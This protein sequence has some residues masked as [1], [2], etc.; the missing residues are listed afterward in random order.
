MDEARRPR[1]GDKA[2]AEEVTRAYDAARAERRL[3]DA[4][5]AKAEAAR[6][7]IDVA[8]RDLEVAETLVV[9]ARKRWTSPRPATTRSARSS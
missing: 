8:N 4:R 2:K 9:K 3:A 7:R 6:T 5:L 1:R